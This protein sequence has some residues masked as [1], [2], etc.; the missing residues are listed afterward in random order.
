MSYTQEKMAKE[1][2]LSVLITFGFAYF[3]MYCIVHSFGYFHDVITPCR[4]ELYMHKLAYLF[5]WQK[6][7]KENIIK[8]NGHD[9]SLLEDCLT[10]I[11]KCYLKGNIYFTLQ[12]KNF[13]VQE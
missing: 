10:W 13:N 12:N 11:T 8:I 1:L 2:A 5:A 9:N 3:P 7:T 4:S 6:S